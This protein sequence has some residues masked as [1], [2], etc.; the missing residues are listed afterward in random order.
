MLNLAVGDGRGA[1]AQVHRQRRARLVAVTAVVALCA[2]ACGSG[3]TGSASGFRISTVA[4]GTV[5]AGTARYIGSMRSNGPG[6]LPVED[7]NF[8]GEIDFTRG[9]STWNGTGHDTSGAPST[10]HGVRLG[11]YEY[12]EGGVGVSDP[13]DP[14]TAAKP[15]TRIEAFPTPLDVSPESAGDVSKLFSQLEHFGGPGEQVGTEAVRGVETTHYRYSIPAYPIP[16]QLVAM[17]SF[18]APAPVT[19]DIWVDAQQR[20]RRLVRGSDP[21]NHLEIEYFDFGAPVTIAAPPADQVRVENIWQVSGDWDLAAQGRAGDAVD[22]KLYRA[23]EADGGTCFAHEAKPP[24]LLDGLLP[25]RRGRSVDACETPAPDDPVDPT[26]QIPSRWPLLSP[27]GVLLAHD[28]VLLF[29]TVD[30]STRGLTMHLDDGHVLHVVPT[31]GLFTVALDA[32]QVVRTI[33]PDIPGHDIVCTLPRPN[34]QPSIGYS[35]EDRSPI[36]PQPPSLGDVSGLP[37]GVPPPEV[38]SPEVPTPPETEPPTV[39]PPG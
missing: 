33:A 13:E 32:H 30:P 31:G 10:T 38:P 37:S 6:N 9:A 27:S 36:R 14:A 26:G 35:C 8:T 19:Y 20:M 34:S 15:W 28:M 12:Y 22:W 24:G 1:G 29:G 18:S 4:G 2:T 7:T 21:Q 39:A 23:P 25:Q 3:S 16:A 5:D 17:G 11:G